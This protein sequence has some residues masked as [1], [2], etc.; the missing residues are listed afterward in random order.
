M[1][2]TLLASFSYLDLY[3]FLTLPLLYSPL[4]GHIERDPHG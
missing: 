3:A 4:T 1:D 2:V